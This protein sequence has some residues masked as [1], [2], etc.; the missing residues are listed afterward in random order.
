MPNT[1]ATQAVGTQPNVGVGTP[2]DPVVEGQPGAKDPVSEEPKKKSGGV[3][4]SLKKN[5]NRLAGKAPK[6]P[7]KSGAAFANSEI[8]PKLREAIAAPVEKQSHGTRVLRKQ[9][10]EISRLEL[11]FIARVGQLCN[12]PDLSS[13]EDPARFADDGPK[14]FLEEVEYLRKR[15]KALALVNEGFASQ[16]K[17]KAVRKETKDLRKLQTMISK[18]YAVRDKGIEGL[19]HTSP[20]LYHAIQTN[21]KAIKCLDKLIARDPDKSRA[22][23][24]VVAGDLGAGRIPAAALPQEGVEEGRPAFCKPNLAT[25][26]THAIVYLSEIHGVVP[27]P[28]KEGVHSAEAALILSLGRAWAL[29]LDFTRPET[30]ETQAENILLQQQLQQT[31]SEIGAAVRSFQTIE[32]LDDIADEGRESQERVDAVESEKARQEKAAEAAEDARIAAMVKAEEAKTDAAR[33]AS[34]A[35]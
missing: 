3:L 28:D 15:S 35:A 13:I 33:V 34:Q 22:I 7:L 27:P 9:D 24:E 12:D 19:Q 8:V 20:K 26:M 31:F 14:A 30:A 16:K 23:I 17:T 18:K 11:A 21:W 4:S 5:I 6:P 29:S 2:L 32:M 10:A 1:V 25:C